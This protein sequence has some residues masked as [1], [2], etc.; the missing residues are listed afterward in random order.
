MLLS[1]FLSLTLSAG[2][3]ASGGAPTPMF[4]P[5]V[6]KML[7]LQLV[8]E[9]R[10]KGCR[11]GE[12]WYPAAPPISWNDLLEKAA[13]NHSVDMNAKSYFSH[14]S[15]NGDKAGQRIDAVGYRWRTYGENIAFGFDT[16]RD[17]VAG[18][19]KS[20]GHCK[21]IMSKDYAEM[22]VARSGQYWTQTFGTR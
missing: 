4:L 2:A 3:P 20:P 6:N 14:S 5:A 10:K 12:T 16:E 19:L 1:L 21:N 15:Q 11:C 13:L 17:V 9:V 8:N 18:W 7:L 22:G